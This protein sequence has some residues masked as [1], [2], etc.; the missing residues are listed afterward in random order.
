MSFKYPVHH[1]SKEELF[2]VR[3]VQSSLKMDPSTTLSRSIFEQG[4]VH[5]FLHPIRVHDLPSEN[6]WRWNQ[7]RKKKE[8]E[9]SGELLVIYKLIP[10]KSKSSASPA[11]PYKLWLV[12]IKKGASFSTILFCERGSCAAPTSPSPLYGSDRA[13]ESIQYPSSSPYKMAVSFL[14]S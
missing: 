14:C 12:T 3:K 8:Q 5:L 9:N 4:K 1:F 6:D 11:P 10:R 7:T 2:V 13:L